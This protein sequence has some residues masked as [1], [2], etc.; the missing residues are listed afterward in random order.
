M[1]LALC[2]WST[3]PAIYLRHFYAPY[4]AISPVFTHP[5]LFS[6]HRTAGRKVMDL[7]YLGGGVLLWALMALLVKGLMR[8]EQ[9]R[10]ER[11]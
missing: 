11:P 3:G 4:Q 5:C 6:R 1:P 7:V 8:L 10:K 2:E 9:P